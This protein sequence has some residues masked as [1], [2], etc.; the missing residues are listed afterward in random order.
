MTNHNKVYDAT[1]NLNHS[2]SQPLQMLKSQSIVILFCSKL[3]IS[4]SQLIQFQIQEVGN[5]NKVGSL[6]R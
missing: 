3:K 1:L 5:W 2:K 4:K 6:I